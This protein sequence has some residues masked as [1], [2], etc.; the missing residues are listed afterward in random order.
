MKTRSM[1]WLALV[2]FMAVPVYAA[3]S[4]SPAASGTAPALVAQ[5]T[6]AAALTAP[7]LS[8]NAA[9][10]VKLSSAG[11]SDDVVLA[12]VK[13]CRFLFNLSANA[14]LGLKEAGVSPRVIAAMLIHDNSLRNPNPRPQYANSQQPQSVVPDVALGDQTPPPTPEEVIPVAPGPDYYWTPGYWGW[15]AGWV[16]VGGS[17]CFRG[18][19]GWGGP[20][21]RGWYGHGGWGGY[22]GGGGGFHGRGG[23]GH[24]SG[25]HGHGGGGHGR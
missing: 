19:Y 18:G 15:N 1:S 22:H 16:W 20:Y 23:G 5:A 24:G 12:Y 6:N 3:Q 2:V 8:R 4:S 21:G 7:A 9:E 14:I 17:W 25:G 10:V 11:F 13:K